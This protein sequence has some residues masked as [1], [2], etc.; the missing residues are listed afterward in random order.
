MKKLFIILIFLFGFS[1][2][3]NAK[4]ISCDFS[5]N[6]Q[7]MQTDVID[8]KTHYDIYVFTLFF[9]DNNSKISKIINVSSETTHEKILYSLDKEKDLPSVF[10]KKEL[11]QSEKNSLVSLRYMMIGMDPNLSSSPEVMNLDKFHESLLSLPDEEK[12]L[13]INIFSEWMKQFDDGTDSM[14]KDIESR[15]SSHDNIMDF[16]FFDSFN[17][18]LEKNINIQ[19][20]NSKRSFK[21]TMDNGMDL[22]IEIDDKVLDTDSM[23]KNAIQFELNAVGKIAPGINEMRLVF[24]GDC[25]VYK[26]NEMTNDKKSELTERLLKLKSLLDDGLISQDQYDLKSSE[27]LNDL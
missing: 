3:I 13:L 4:N 19:R 2:N 5:L 25:K 20:I 8:V 16:W 22:R 6:E 23:I 15:M 11:N 9:E 17:R 18:I 7:E 21:G 1:A 14:L 24:S 26:K 27:I 10:Y 12:K